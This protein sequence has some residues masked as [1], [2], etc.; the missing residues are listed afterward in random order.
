MQYNNIFNHLLDNND[1][2]L[3]IILFLLKDTDVNYQH[4]EDIT[5]HA[6]I[7]REKN[8]RNIFDE[9]KINQRNTCTHYHHRNNNSAST[10]HFKPQQI[11]NNNVIS[12]ISC[13][14]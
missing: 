14:Q 5:N 8:L 10:F 6:T 2:I 4:D 13:S 7:V 1:I 11:K 3:D 12:Y 9:H